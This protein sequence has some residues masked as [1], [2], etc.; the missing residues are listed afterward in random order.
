MTLRLMS[1]QGNI[2]S[3]KEEGNI[4]TAKEVK[5]RREG[6]KCVFVLKRIRILIGTLLRTQVRLFHRSLKII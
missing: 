2:E 1:E 6:T 5:A 4:G 3:V